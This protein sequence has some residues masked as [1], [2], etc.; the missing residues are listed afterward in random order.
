MAVV[1]SRRRE[2]EAMSYVSHTS[3]PFSCFS[4]AL[5]RV[6]YYPVASRFPLAAS[7][8]PRVIPDLALKELAIGEDDLLA[9]VA[10]DACRFEPDVLHLAAVILH[11]DRITHHERLVEHDGDGGKQ[12]AEDV[13]HGE[14]DGDTANS[15]PGEK[16]LDLDLIG[17][18]GNNGKDDPDREAGDGAQRLEC[19][20][21]ATIRRVGLDIPRQVVADDDVGPDDALHEEGERRCN[22]CLVLGGLR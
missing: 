21:A 16:R 1:L 8:L 2:L 18:E 7:R 20:N 12:V 13:L 15:Q 19:G 14:R 3:H 11:R 5:F 6:S 17:A 22:V 10:A 9:G 4:I